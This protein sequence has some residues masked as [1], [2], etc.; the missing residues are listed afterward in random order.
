MMM[1]IENL[2]PIG[3]FILQ[4]TQN[5]ISSTNHIKHIDAVHFVQWISENYVMAQSMQTW[6]KVFFFIFA[7]DNVGE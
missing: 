1:K 7:I 3:L 6:I 2:L 5:G 4:S